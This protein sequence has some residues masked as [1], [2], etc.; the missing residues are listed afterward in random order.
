MSHFLVAWIAGSLGFL[1]GGSWFAIWDRRDKATSG[2]PT[3]R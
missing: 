3:N 1:L 2:D